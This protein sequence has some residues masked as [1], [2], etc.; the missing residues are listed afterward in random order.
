MIRALALLTLLAGCGDERHFFVRTSDGAH[1]KV[2]LRGDP[3]SDALIVLLHGGPAGDA[4]PYKL[5]TAAEQLEERVAIAYVDQR[6]RGASQRIRGLSNYTLDRAGL[7]VQDVVNVLRLRYGSSKRL[8]LYGHSWGGSLGTKALLDTSVKESID[9]WIEAAG[10]HDSVVEPVYVGERLRAQAEIELAEGRQVGFWER[11]LENLDEID[12]ESLP[13]PIGDLAWLNDVGYRAEQRTEFHQVFEDDS[14]FPLMSLYRSG[15]RPT[16]DSV[17][18]LDTLF[19][20]WLEYSTLDRLGEI[21]V[22]ALYLYADYD[23]V[24][25]VR[26]G[27]D[28][29]AAN[30]NGRLVVFEASGH[31]LMVNETGKY[32]EEILG[33]VQPERSR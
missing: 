8:F 27:E 28:A 25:P 16:F 15:Y 22:P 30:P 5:G 24:C 23:F 14:Q 1:L 12:F 7:D 26:L 9:G 21:D 33:F 18:G 29:V 20:E 11:V 13:L 3:D 31:S 2:H 4:F 32:V 10:C 6:G 19:Y 17:R